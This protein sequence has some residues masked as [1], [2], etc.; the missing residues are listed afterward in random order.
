[1]GSE[2]CIRDRSLMTWDYQIILPEGAV[3]KKEY[4]DKIEE[5]GILE[6]YVKEDEANEI[7]ILKNDIEKNGVSGGLS[8]IGSANLIRGSRLIRIVKQ[9]AAAAC[10]NLAGVS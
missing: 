6:V 2:M 4:I 7:V 1:M 10:E 3:L 5:M 9:Q 8:A